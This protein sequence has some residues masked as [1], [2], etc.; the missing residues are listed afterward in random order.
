[1]KL[2]SIFVIFFLFFLFFIPT[3]SSC[4]VCDDGYE[5]PDLPDYYYEHFDSF[6]FVESTDFSSDH[7]IYAYAYNKDDYYIGVYTQNLEQ[8]H[9]RYNFGLF[10]KN[11][12]DVKPL[13]RPL[14]LKY[15]EQNYFVMG[16]NYWDGN[17]YSG[18]LS[19]V[20]ENSPWISP[21]FGCYT[22][23]YSYINDD[24]NLLLNKIILTTQNVYNKDGTEV[25]VS[26]PIL[27]TILNW[28]EVQ[29]GNFDYL[30][31]S[32]GSYDVELDVLDFFVYTNFSDV[33]YA[34][35]HV[36]IAL[37]DFYVRSGSTT[38]GE[39]VKYYDIPSSE[40]GVFDEGIK[41]GFGLN[42]GS[43]QLNYYEFTCGALSEEDQQQQ[44]ENAIVSGIEEQ[45]KTNKSIWETLKEVLSYINP[46]S[47]NFFVYKLI[48][49]LIDAIKSLFLPSEDFITNWVTDMN[50]WLNDRLG[51]LY[52]P[53]DLVINFLER[54]GSL[55]DSGTAVI[56]WNDFEFMGATIIPAY[57][58]DFYDLLDNETFQ[59]VHS[60]YLICVDVILYVFL[61]ILAKNT[62][63]DVFGGQYDDGFDIV[64]SNISAEAKKGG[65]K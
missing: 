19:F 40:F 8:G 41:Y 61:I 25:V 23:P 49:L 10:P 2:K 30:R 29:T 27:P 11:P 33:E 65:K 55:S 9:T 36:S 43:N 38:G 54:I 58:F 20:I 60:F 4:F 24:E 1:M 3:F 51:F 34:A 45:N 39:I 12:D 21:T 18:S 42:D 15:G 52:Y 5:Y 16:G 14:R 17:S 56:R 28:E 47:E 13:A 22:I 44:L 50:D 57:S 37:D 64:S 59:N 7:F 46:F 32:S 53:I 26:I 63:T 31:I 6:F 48:E 35:K 62:F